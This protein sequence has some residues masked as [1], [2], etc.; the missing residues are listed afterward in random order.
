MLQD[1]E[2]VAIQAYEFWCSISDEEVTRLMNNREIACLSLKA[3]PTLWS[4]MK[5]H[6]LNR[7]VKAEKEDPDAWNNVRAASSLLE[8][9]CLC[10]NDTL[11]DYIFQMISEHINSENAKIRDSVM[12]AFGS[13]LSCTTPKLQAILPDAFE[14]I[15]SMLADNEQDVRVTVAWCL[16]KISEYHSNIFKTNK[17]LLDTLIKVLIGNIS[18]NKKVTTYICDTLHH[19][20][21]N[22]K[23]HEMNGILTPYY[24]D[25]LTALLQ[26]AFEANAYN[27][28]NN[29]ALSCLYTVG[30]LVDFC[31]PDAYTI[32]D[33][34]FP[35]IV[36]AFERTTQ[37]NNGFQGEEPKRLA[38]Q[39]YLATI[40][41]ACTVEG[42][43]TLSKDQVKHL[44]NLL[45]QTFLER[46]AVYEEGLMACSSLATCIGRDFLEYIQDFGGFL[47]WGLDH[48]QDVS[49][50]RIAINSTSDIIRSI[51]A[52]LAPYM[53]EIIEKIIVILQVSII[54]I[55]SEQR[56]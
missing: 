56:Y 19:L 25:L 5:H 37:L 44:F 42:K 11:I 12:L 27:S 38:Y 24:P 43:V 18:G 9:L 55:T 13:I 52:D 53:K 47:V 17:V 54:R 16:K 3:L 35:Q 39:G 45:K 49:L 28:E 20:S 7:N 15:L 40:I 2:R 36:G 31:S 48:W 22:L 4:V 41:S 26:T 46:N 32:I 33:Q 29:I 30:S 23:S 14:K 1:D 50:C 21:L 6:Y 8:N 10:T 34:I 51:G